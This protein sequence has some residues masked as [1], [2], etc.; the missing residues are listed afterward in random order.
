[1]DKQ[2]VNDMLC[3]VRRVGRRVRVVAPGEPPIEGTLTRKYDQDTR[4]FEIRPDG[5][6]LPLSL[7]PDY[8]ESVT[9]ADDAPTID[10]ARAPTE[11][12]KPPR[13]VR[14]SMPWGR[15]R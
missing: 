2:T 15:D 1:M 8:L 11:R 12:A 3:F 13:F 7:F 10:E 4:S 5:S 9:Y 14:T 6:E